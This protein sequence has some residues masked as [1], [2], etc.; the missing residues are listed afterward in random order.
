MICRENVIKK[1]VEIRE[2]R[3]HCQCSRAKVV[4]KNCFD[5][6]IKKIECF[7]EEFTLDFAES[8]LTAER[9]SIPIRNDD[10]RIAYNVHGYAIEVCKRVEGL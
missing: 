10:L 5:Q 8:Y 9:D 7:P 6:V 3:T 4:E 1:L 2:K